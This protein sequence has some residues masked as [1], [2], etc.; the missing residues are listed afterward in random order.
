MTDRTWTAAVSN[1]ASDPGNWSPEGAPAPGD[2]LLVPFRGP[3]ITMDI[4][5][6]AL[7]GDPLTL[8]SGFNSL[9]NVFNLSQN[10]EASLDFSMAAANADVVNIHGNGTLNASLLTPDNHL[11]I[12]LASRANLFGVLD[13]NRYS[14]LTISGSGQVP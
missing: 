4:A 1:T 8:I 2:T 14:T 12:N 9:P 5:G 6:D 11:T 7:A 3:G 10:G 13:G